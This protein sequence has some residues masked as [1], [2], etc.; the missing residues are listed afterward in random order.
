MTPAS[1]RVRTK[2]RDSSPPNATVIPFIRVAAA[3]VVVQT[4]S[5]RPRTVMTTPELGDSVERRRLSRRSVAA[6]SGR[7]VCARSISDSTVDAS[8]TQREDAERDEHR[9]G[10]R[11]EQ[12][13]R[14]RLRDQRHVVL[15]GLRTARRSTIHITR[16]RPLLPGEGECNANVPRD[17]AAL[18]PSLGYV[19]AARGTVRLAGSRVLHGRA[20]GPGLRR[21]RRIARRRASSRARRRGE[22]EGAVHATLGADPWTDTHLRTE[23]VE[24]WT[25]RLDGRRL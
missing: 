21:P 23:S 4:A 17:E 22:S 3:E 16:M 14:E 18:G 15:P 1:R 13:V 12:R 11:E 6:S 7:T 20:R 2:P 9:G 5:A 25:I 19:S 24:P 10:D 8:A